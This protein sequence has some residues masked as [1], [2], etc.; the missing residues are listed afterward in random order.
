MEKATVVYVAERL[1]AVICVAIVLTMHMKNTGTA[2]RAALTNLKTTNKKQAS[3][4]F[5]I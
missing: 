3:C 2:C 1:T 5:M 4:C